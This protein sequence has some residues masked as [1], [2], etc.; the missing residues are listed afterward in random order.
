[1]TT[2]S[3]NL[4]MTERLQ[5]VCAQYGMKYTVSGPHIQ[6]H[7]DSERYK[8]FAVD[9][10]LFASDSVEACLGWLMGVFGGYASQLVE[11]KAFVPKEAG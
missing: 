10:T 7:A 2:S 5:Q 9:N 11:R 1:M 3:N 4:L 6:I 8:A